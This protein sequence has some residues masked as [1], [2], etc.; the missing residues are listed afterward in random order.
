MEELLAT[1]GIFAATLIS[2][3]IF[4]VQDGN[5]HGG[6]GW[7]RDLII[8]N[9]IKAKKV[10]VALILM[11]VPVLFWNLGVEFKIAIVVGY[12]FGSRALFK[13]F[14]RAYKWA[15]AIDGV[16][17]W[18]GNVNYRVRKRLE[19]L[20]SPSGGIENKIIAW[21]SVFDT[22]KDRKSIIEERLLVKEFVSF[23][24]RSAKILK[25]KQT[26]ALFS[27]LGQNI[28]N[29][30]LDDP[31]VQENL[32][33]VLFDWRHQIFS[34]S[35]QSS[36]K[37]RNY[38]MAKMELD[39]LLKM[40]ISY[41]IEN[42]LDY[43]LFQI[44]LPEHVENKDEEYIQDLFIRVI[45]RETFESAPDSPDSFSF[46]DNSL[47][48]GWKVRKK[49]PEKNEDQTISVTFF[50]Q[51]A[52]WAQRRLW[53]STDGW[54][55][56]LEDVTLGLFPNINNRLFATLFT[57]I[58]RPYSDSRVADL[59]EKDLKFGFIGPTISGWGEEEDIAR[60]FREL[61]ESQTDYTL[62]FFISR[63]NNFFTRENV[64][65]F[66]NEAEHLSYPNNPEKDSK[67][68][69]VVSVFKK[70]LEKLTSTNS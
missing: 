46:W 65:M 62:D 47:P 1:T 6:Y 32:V 37:K 31:V 50:H 26:V 64:S 49:Q 12:F 38:M 15:T 5:H 43:P 10:F 3:S 54:D 7:D 9:V 29:I 2:V 28:S 8:K 25:Q 55:K 41:M 23:Y 19:Y 16:N 14:S 30:S 34:L 4:L 11:T 56:K 36:D 33:G 60:K 27:A 17:S 20:S 67:R 58:F 52:N 39:R 35:E 59:V 21:E 13:A 24:K 42:G 66:L 18:S 48:P 68:E 61:E 44:T 51:Y 40:I 63:F 53:D 45:A 22:S 69:Y 57:L 70:L